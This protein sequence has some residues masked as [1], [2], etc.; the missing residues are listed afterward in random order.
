ME[1]EEEEERETWPEYGPC[2]NSL[3]LEAG[4]GDDG[5]L[6]LVVD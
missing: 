4:G 1:E 2:G 3:E 6:V 5:R